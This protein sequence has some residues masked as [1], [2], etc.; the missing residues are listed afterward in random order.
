[1]KTAAISLMALLI[2]SPLVGATP[3]TLKITTP[4]TRPTTNG[5]LNAS[6][7][8]T[9]AEPINVYYS[10]N[11]SAWTLAT[12]SNTWSVSGLRPTAGTNTF[13]AYAQDA[14]T[15]SKT[16]TVKFIYVVNVPVTIQ[17]NGEG[18][19][20]PLHNDES[21][22]IGKKYSLTA[23]PA[24]G[25]GFTGWTLNDEPL[26]NASRISFIMASN[27]SLTASFRDFARPVC[28][29]TFPVSKHNVT[30][31]PINVTGRASDNVGVTGV[32]VNLSSMGWLPAK[33]DDGTNWKVDY[34]FLNQGGNTL[35]AYAVDAAGNASLTNTVT[36][37]CL[38]DSPAVTGSAPASLAGLFG[39]VN[40]QYQPG[41][42]QICFGSSTFG[43]VFTN[44]IGPSYVGNYAYTLMSSNVAQLLITGTINT[45]PLTTILTFVNDST[46]IFNGADA[47]QG[48][49]SF[50]AATNLV[51]P[52]SAILTLQCVDTA[53]NTN[54]LAL[55][56]GLFTNTDGLTYTNFG[57]SYFA[58]F[59][60][61]DMMLI[62]N[63]TD[64]A[65]TGHVDYV[66]L[67]FSTA[68]TGQFFLNQ[69]DTPGNPLNEGDSGT[70]T[71]L[72]T[73]SPPAG[74]A[75]DSL[76][77]LIWDVTPTDESPFQLCFGTNTYSRT[78][79]DTN[80]N[81]VGDYSFIRTGPDSAQFSDIESAPS[82][83]YNEYLGFPGN[84]VYLTFNSTNAATFLTTNID[85]GVTNVETG[86]VSISLATTNLV[87]ASLAGKTIN[88]TFSD[89]TETV[90]LD[91][92]G[93]NTH[94]VNNVLTDSGSYAYAQYSPIG[95]LLY[96][97][98]QSGNVPDYLELTFSSSTAG[99]IFAT[100]FDQSGNLTEAQS[101]TFT[102]Q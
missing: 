29:I 101:G 42:A 63:F 33:L 66:Q 73:A 1:M 23:K 54:T 65:D 9:G 47:Y 79:A 12:G 53:G 57:T 31:T 41:L 40:L 15:A 28:I 49:I 85:N 50:T 88:A 16:N 8:A 7:T 99:I 17:I 70:F 13:S 37:N 59:S 69:F 51:P 93:D 102:T 78:S 62:E 75:P 30:N 38:S 100:E 56:E 32:F 60:P 97:S 14:A 11:G 46:A 21:L 64:A 61:M 55:G 43:E 68:T 77:S 91:L 26:T 96:L 84:P 95:A 36:F 34:L 81:D 2:A 74:N 27:L 90:T 98:N 86:T 6:G 94:E 3:P 71:F 20:T 87:P 18:T 44:G 83:G 72:G 24:K 45:S 35:Q 48:Y 52:S 89:H 80:K 19:V 76:A 4:A 92:Q 67:D 39:Q 10:F 82:P 22:E 5:V 25:F 58:P